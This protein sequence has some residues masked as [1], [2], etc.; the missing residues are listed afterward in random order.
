MFINP[1]LH[2][3]QNFQIERTFLKFLIFY[4]ENAKTNFH[5]VRF[6]DFRA[7]GGVDRPVVRAVE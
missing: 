5:V 7:G 3:C 4:E 2:F 1:L 6:D